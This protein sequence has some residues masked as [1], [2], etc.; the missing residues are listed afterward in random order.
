MLSGQ[1]VPEPPPDCRCGHAEA[2]HVYGTER[3]NTP[4]CGCREYRPP[5][6]RPDPPIPDVTLT[7]GPTDTKRVRMALRTGV[8]IG[9][10]DVDNGLVGVLVPTDEWQ[11]LMRLKEEANG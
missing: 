2:A 10:Y 6:E 3:C 11:D 7:L 8:L 4:G 1:P 5:C 9:I